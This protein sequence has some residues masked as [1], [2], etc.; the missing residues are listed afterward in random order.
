[1]ES[2]FIYTPPKGGKKQRISG[3]RRKEIYKKHFSKSG[4]VIVVESYLFDKEEK[5]KAKEKE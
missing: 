2:K 5:Y 3:K 1:M 4:C